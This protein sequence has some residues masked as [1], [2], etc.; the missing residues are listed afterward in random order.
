MMQ[1]AAIR[2]YLEAGEYDASPRAWPGEHYVDQEH[3]QHEALK[4]A[5][6]AEVRRLAEGTQPPGLPEGLDLTA[7][8]RARAAP[9]VRGLFPARECEAVLRLLERSVVFLTAENIERVLTE[10]TWLHTAWDLAHLYLGSLGRPGLHGRQDCILGLSQEKTC[11]VTL[12]YFTAQDRFADFVVHEAAHIFHNWKRE[13]AGLPHSRTREWLLAIE[14]R[15]RETFAYACEAY[16]RILALGRRRSERVLLLEEY[17]ASAAPPDE[18]ADA[19][20]VIDIL[21]GAIAARNG[22][23][24][25]LARCAPPRRGRRIALRD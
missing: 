8:T 3:A 5:L 7:F 25:I 14:F 17:A 18:R 12:A 4:G 24:R 22:W 13:Y 23:K 9:M 16:S 11:F 15:K 21:R 10:Q 20:E 6:I 19:A 2:R 1:A